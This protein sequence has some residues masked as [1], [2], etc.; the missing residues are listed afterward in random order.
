MQCPG[1]IGGWQD[2]YFTFQL[3]SEY[4]RRMGDITVRVTNTLDQGAN[5]ESIGYGDMSFVYEFSE[6]RETEIA[7]VDEGV[8]NPTALW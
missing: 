8:E 3:E 7:N 2:G 5:D 1:S 4:A 6:G